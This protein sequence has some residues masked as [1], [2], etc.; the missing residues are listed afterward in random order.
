[1]ATTEMEIKVPGGR[2]IAAQIMPD[3]I[4]KLT[5]EFEDEKHREIQDAKLEENNQE[6]ITEESSKEEKE[7]VVKTQE[8]DDV[9]VERKSHIPNN[10]IW[11]K[12]EASKLS[13]NQEFMKYEPTHP[14][15]KEFKELLVKAISNGELRD[16]YRPI[17]DP[18]FDADKE[19]FDYVLDKPVAV[20]RSFNWC[21]EAA[22][23]FMPECNSRLGTKTEYVAFMAMLIK[24]LVENGMAIDEAW[25]TVCEDSKK[26]GHYWNS[27]NSAHELEKTGSRQIC[28]FYDLGNTYKMLVAENEEGFYLA[29]GHYFNNSNSRPLAGFCYNTDK[30]STNNFSVA[31]IVLFDD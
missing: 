31:W 14:K 6:G 29:G 2:I 13:L 27:D 17:C 25:K 8:K 20:G 15:T 26:I 28:G 18:A 3:G 21:K 9:K 24:L 16:F 11:V 1:M 30:G 23:K 4:C 5:I 7:E 10:G 12:I 19:K 22:S